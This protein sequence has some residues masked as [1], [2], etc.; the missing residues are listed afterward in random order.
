MN[1]TPQTRPRPDV[2]PGLLSVVSPVYGCKSCLESLAERSTIAIR[3]LGMEAEIILV[4]DNSPDGAWSRIEELCAVHP[5][6]RGLRLSRNF[7]Q[8]YAIAAG[9]EQARGELVAVMDCDL[10]DLPEELPKLV[11][12]I[13]EGHDVAFAQRIERQDSAFKRFTSYAFFRT[14]SYLTDTHQ[15]HSTANFGVFTRQVIDTVNTMSESDRCF[16]LMVKWSGFRQAL[17]PVKHAER[18]EGQSGYSFRKLLR[19]AINIV[20]SYSDKPLRLVVKLGL[21]FSLFAFCVVLLSVYR[22]S[23]GDIAVAGF[24]SV[25]ASIWLLGGVMIFCVGIIGLYLG[26]LFNDAKGRPYYIISKQ[27][28]APKDGSE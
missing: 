14:L 15:D 25:I 2:K 16:P 9:I 18:S 10:Q 8:H 21:A 26:R 27:L 28:N 7:G 11:A 4:D 23:V 20:L 13:R 6:V 1:G 5:H 19:L 24:T 17:V 3:Q 12:A 22:Y